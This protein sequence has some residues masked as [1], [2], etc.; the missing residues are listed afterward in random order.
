MFK[1]FKV[2]IIFGGGGARGISHLGALRIL[3]GAGI[4]IDIISG[5][6]FGAV[7]GA[8]Y[9]IQPNIQLV[10]EKVLKF[11]KGPAFKRTRFEF[12]RHD[13]NDQKKSGFFSKLSSSI[14]KGVFYGISIT[15]P[16][17]LSEEEYFK[18]MAT[19]IE[20]I[21]IEETQIPFLTTAGDLISGREYVLEKGSLRRAICA[22][23]AIPGAFPPIPYGERLLVD[24]GWVNPIPVDL[25]RERGADLVIVIHASDSLK[26]E[27]EMSRGL[28]LLL[29]ADAMVREQLVSKSL[30]NA[31]IWIKPDVGE[32]HWADFSRPKEYIQ[33]GIE[34]AEEK[35]GEIRQKIRW[36]KFRNIFLNPKERV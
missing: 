1:P 10:E 5:V 34:A 9:A 4:P 32:V 21:Q 20:D 33:K 19:I 30:K 27:K 13:F 25:I 7:I 17:Y 26:K 24:G 18:I 2:G 36:R 3:E 29:R 8:L 15:R 28:D 16:A 11:L 22:T 12:L 6:S 35:I 31:D 14:K 23:C